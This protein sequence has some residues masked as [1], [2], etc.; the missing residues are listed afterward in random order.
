MPKILFKQITYSLT[1]LIH[2]I[3]LGEIGLPD[4]QRPFVWEAAKVRDLFDSMYQ[5]FPVGYLLLWA[6]D[7]LT[8]TRH[9]GTTSKQVKTPR[10]LIVDGQ[11]RLTCLY[12][13]FKGHKV[14]TKDFKE[15]QIQIAFRP[16]DAKFEV[17]DAAI[18]R[19]PEYIFNI[20][21]LW[22]DSTD[23]FEFV[24]SYFERLS[25]VREVSAEERKKIKQAIG[26]LKSLENYSFTVL[27]IASTVDEEKVSEI[28]V[29]INSQGVKLKQADFI[30]TLLSVFWD[31]GRSQLEKFCRECR[32]PPVSSAP[33]P[34]NYFIQPD[35]DQILRVCVGLGFKRARL[36]YVYSI[37]RGKDLETGKISDKRRDEQFAILKDSQ[38]KT[39]DL[40]NWHEFQ[41]ALLQAGFRS[42]G[43]ISSEIGVLYAYVIF[44]L[45]KYEFKVSGHDLR[46][47][48]GRWF[49]MTAITG[50]YTSSPETIMESDL[51]RL[52][53]VKSAEE[54]TSA[55]DQ[56]IKDT[57]TKDYWNITLVNA[58]ETSSAR[59]P[60]LFAYYAALNLLSAK[61]LFSELTLSQ[62]LDPAIKAKKSAVE[63]H[64]LFPKAYLKES[65]ITEVRHTNQIANY[66]LVEWADNIQISDS[67][68]AIYFPKYAQNY[69]KNPE[70]LKQMMQWHALPQ[71]WEQMEYSNFLIHRRKLIAQVIREGFERL[72]S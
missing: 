23:I 58:L 65:G 51:A 20:S 24:D 29:R 12:A 46:K 55:L 14:L 15:V 27:E 45:G 28:F 32:V 19:D 36:Q 70:E 44:L 33:C 50:R 11:Q 63:R 16:A 53:A 1:S 10:L 3:E 18:Q 35:P 57:L 42:K 48:I 9:I 49:F 30:L 37:L 66:A 25:K 56:I 61:V 69:D 21:Q 54:F 22:S 6:N 31:E 62:L 13:V 2:D 5:G 34:F 39:L 41:K 8:N 72:M 43:M 60:V 71:D 26:D 47:V 59:T 17:A 68:P 4:I 7:H 67:S 40:T 38:A 64:H 52:R